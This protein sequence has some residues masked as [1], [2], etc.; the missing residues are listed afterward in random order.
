MSKP[1]AKRS[2]AGMRHVANVLVCPHKWSSARTQNVDMRPTGGKP[3][4]VKNAS[5]MSCELC[6]T[7]RVDHDGI[8]SLFPKQS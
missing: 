3:R 5:V 8:S 7:I 1:K 2:D 6:G 4:L